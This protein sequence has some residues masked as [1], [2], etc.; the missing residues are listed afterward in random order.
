MGEACKCFEATRKQMEEMGL[1]MDITE[2]IKVEGKNTRVVYGIRVLTLEGR[3]PPRG[4]P[5]SLVMSF[6]PLC[7]KELTR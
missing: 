6:C 5:T 7:G 3:K 1:R 4:S 2:G